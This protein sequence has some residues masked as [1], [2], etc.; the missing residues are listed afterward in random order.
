MAARI[1]FSMGYDIIGDVHGCIDELTT[2]L[3]DLGYEAEST[4]DSTAFGTPPGRSAVFLGDLVNRGPDTPGVLRLVMSMVESG[5]ALGV[6]GN[7]DVTLARALAGEPI[8]NPD[9]VKESMAQ[10][11][12][13][14]AAFKAQAVAF[15]NGLPRWLSL[16]EGR[17]IVAHAGLPLEYH[18]LEASEEADDFAVNGRKVPDT[19]GQLVRYRWA[20]DD[21]GEATVAYGHYSGPRAEWLNNTICLDTGCVYG[22]SLTALRYPERELV[23]I[24]ASRTY[25]ETDRSE[26]FRTAA[27]ELSRT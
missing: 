18:N 6:A 7:H 10:M 25:Y 11:V 21:R 24:P 1:L 13:E 16:D 14:P 20:S 12:D 8:D 17:L 23:S 22:G 4:S 26:E 27:A 19:S 2:L 3:T 5:S 9:H 15:I